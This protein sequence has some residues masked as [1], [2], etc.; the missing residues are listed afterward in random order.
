VKL[1]AGQKARAEKIVVKLTANLN[2]VNEERKARNK[3]KKKQKVKA[4]KRKV[5]ESPNNQPVNKR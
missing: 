3:T 5:P 2:Q 1:R 4:N